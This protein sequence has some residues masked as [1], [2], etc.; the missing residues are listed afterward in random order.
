MCLSI[1][2]RDAVF[3]QEKRQPLGEMRIDLKLHLFGIADLA[4]S[5][6][7]II[8][9]PGRCGVIHAFRQLEREPRFPA[10]STIFS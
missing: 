8:L 3:D 9:S 10:F 6:H 1:V 7:G 4:H 5:D 2:K